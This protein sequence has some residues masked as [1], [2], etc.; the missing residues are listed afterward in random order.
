MHTDRVR[1][2]SVLGALGLVVAA[3]TGCS[4]APGHVGEPAIV[5]TGSA[6]PE[7]GSGPS[8]Q[9]SPDSPATGNTATSAAGAAHSPVSTQGEGAA[10]NGD[11]DLDEGSVVV[12]LA[13]SAENT[14][15]DPDSELEVD[16]QV[17]DGTR[18][19]IAEAW[20]S[21]GPGFV[22]V[23]DSSLQLLGTSRVGAGTEPVTMAIAA[24]PTSNPTAGR[25]LAVLY[26]D[27][28]DGKADPVRD[29]LVLDDDGEVEAED[30]Y[31]RSGG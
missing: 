6:P 12:S 26:L 30:F 8:G 17:G 9:S 27:D 10:A 19:A 13:E 15:V 4:A 2:V 7:P 24:A 3:S 11:S 14:V 1:M 20:L 25:L 18:V 22:A 29:S 28:G 31:Y 21:G 23:Y 16:D 5:L